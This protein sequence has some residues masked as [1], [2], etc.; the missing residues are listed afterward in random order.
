MANWFKD[1]I[2]DYTPTLRRHKNIKTKR[3]NGRKI[4]SLFTNVTKAS[5]SVWR[6][7]VVFTVDHQKLTR[8]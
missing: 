8:K 4:V 7:I 1:K 2:I 6:I 3:L 5:D